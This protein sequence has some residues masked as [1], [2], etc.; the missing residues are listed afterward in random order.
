MN[1]GTT[2]ICC[3]LAAFLLLGG[4]AA[5]GGATS[6]EPDAYV[7]GAGYHMLMAEIA[8]ERGIEPTAAEEYLNAAERSDDP[9]ESQRAAEFAFQYGF[10]AWALRAARRWSELSPQESTARLYLARLLVRRNDVEGAT[11]QA[12]AA[13]GPAAQ[14]TDEDYSLLAGE[15]GEEGNLEGVTR[16]WSR[17]AATAPPMPALQTALASAALRSRDF[18]LALASARAAVDPDIAWPSDAEAEAVIGRAL[19][20][21]GDVDA[22]LAHAR[23]QAAARPGVDSE[24]EYANLLAAA[25]RDGEALDVLKA[26]EAK[27]GPQPA[28][29]RLRGLVSLNA[30]DY[31]TAWEQFSSLV[32]NDEYGDE[33]YFHLAEIALRQEQLEVAL[34]MLARVDD[35]P[36]LLLARDTLARIAVARGDSQGALQLLGELAERHPELAFQAERRRA[37]ILQKTGDSQQALDVLDGV[38]RYQPDDAELRVNRGALQEQMGR[39]EPALADMAAAAALAPDNAAVLNAYGYTLANHDGSTA[40]AYGLVRRALE[41]DPGD[42]AIL[43]SYGWVLYRQ[44]RL[45]EARSYLELAHAGLP[46]PEVAAHLGEVMWKQGDRAGARKVWEEALQAAPGSKPLQDTMAR[47]LR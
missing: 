15:L 45:P 24:L 44:G 17:L 7:P 27:Y 14:R 38:V 39:I 46:D 19:L 18:D 42:P 25:E 21:R 5:R 31:K 22:A 8:A 35:G 3:A 43:D 36:Y 6:E 12:G 40:E 20:A 23:E 29:R 33:S 2:G 4:C 30:G 37:A 11:A 47:F 41:R 10:D 1:T 16:V 28:A 34:Q 32:S 26:L 9:A 13:L